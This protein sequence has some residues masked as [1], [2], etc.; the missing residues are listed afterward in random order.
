M[1]HFYMVLNLLVMN[2]NCD[3]NTAQQSTEIS[4]IK[5]SS[6]LEAVQYESVTLSSLSNGS[7]FIVYNNNE[8]YEAEYL[9]DILQ[10]E[11]SQV[12]KV[13][14]E[15]LFISMEVNENSNPSTSSGML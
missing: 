3:Y 15:S 12:M 7:V 8:Q 6:E 11:V 2:Y 4:F 10:Y 1:S 13:N 5:S 14:E 9:N